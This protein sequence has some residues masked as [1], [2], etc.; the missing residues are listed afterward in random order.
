MDSLEGKTQAIDIDVIRAVAW[1]YLGGS[2]AK[3]PDDDSSFARAKML[4]LLEKTPVWGVTERGM[5]A[6]IASGYIPGEP[7]PEMAGI[8]LLW[9]IHLRDESIPQCIGALPEA[10][11]D[12]WPEHYARLRAQME[13]DY[14]SFFDS[15]SDVKSFFITHVRVN[16]PPKHEDV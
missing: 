2:Q 6:L 8:H 12:S 4:G 10:L 1:C 11:C 13:E 15:P 9:A 16:L 5:G 14:K 7:A 3:R